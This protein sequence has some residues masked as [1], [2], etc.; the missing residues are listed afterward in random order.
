LG[1][2]RDSSTD[3]TGRR[4]W[5]SRARLYLVFTPSLCGDRDPL[6][7]LGAVLPSVDLIQVRPKPLGDREPASSAR[8]AYDWTVRVLERVRATRPEVPVIVNDRVDVA[9]SLASRGCA[10]V[11]LGQDDASP[12]LART[13]LGEAALIGLS[14]HDAVQVA[15]AGEEPVDYLGFGPFRA[16]ATKGYGRGL[17]P[18]AC[19]V[20]HHAA[21]AP[22]FPIGG[23]TIETAGELA[24]IGRAAVGAGVLSAPDPARAARMIRS[25]LEDG[26]D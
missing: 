19:L 26:E 14:T 17:G 5:L 9:A 2:P 23:V 1:E 21:H 24:R 25:L 7:V 15:R 16:S 11:H 22:V 8:E 12:A 4:A 20:A 3:A 13:L 6:G 10:G 18:E